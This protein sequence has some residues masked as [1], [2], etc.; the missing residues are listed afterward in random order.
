M[1]DTRACGFRLR[2]V[3]NDIHDGVRAE[4][5]DIH[6]ALTGR[7]DFVCG[8]TPVTSSGTLELRV[9]KAKVLGREMRG[10]RSAGTLQHS[11]PEQLGCRSS[12]ATLALNG[13]LVR[14]G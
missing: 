6:R 11:E 14:L 7:L 4:G 5:R 1:C 8:G 10:I 3:V 9:K 2:D 13:R 12:G